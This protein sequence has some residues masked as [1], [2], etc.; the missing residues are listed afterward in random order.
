V[1]FGAVGDLHGDFDV[2]HRIMARHPEVELWLCPGDLASDT[3]EYPRP[4][5]PLYWIKGNNEDFDFVASQ[6]AGSGTIPYLHYI[7]NG[8]QI[9]ARGL[10]LAGLGGTFAPTWYETP[11]SQLPRTG[12]RVPRGKRHEAASESEALGPHER[13]GPSG[14]GVP[15]A[16]AA[17]GCLRGPRERQRPGRAWPPRL[18][19]S[20]ERR[21]A[22]G[23]PQASGEE[24]GEGPPRL[25]NDDK[26]RHFVH[27]EVDV[28]RQLR[29]IDVFL[30]HEAPRPFLLEPGRASGGA[31][32]IDAGK[33][34][35]NEIL[36]AMQPRLHLFGHHHRYSVAERQNV[37]SIGLDM[38]S[39]SYLIFDSQTLAHR[40]MTS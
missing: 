29:G 36:N 32:K 38:A 2:L 35:I 16:A 39:E 37:P 30:S 13:R 20:R 11:A 34:P 33:T 8:V 23:P 21:G 17:L 18:K 28:C 19:K 7:P 15:N 4:P 26:R 27:Q 6:P 5:A 24:R 9:D 12:E 22:T 25:I 3:G 1:T 40:R 14:G 10:N 31:R